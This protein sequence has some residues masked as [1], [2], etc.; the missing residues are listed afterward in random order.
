[1]SIENIIRMTDSEEESYIV[2]FDGVDFGSTMTYTIVTDKKF[3]AVSIERLKN[4]LLLVEKMQNSTTASIYEK[5]PKQSNKNEL[6]ELLKNQRKNADLKRFLE[7]SRIL[8]E[9]Y[10]SGEKSVD[11]KFTDTDY[12][13]FSDEIGP[14]LIEVKELKNKK[15]H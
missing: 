9:N 7:L 4:P 2:D 5:E 6:L 15:R 10:S 11:N 13:L 1:M 3:E 8:L 12:T 14:L